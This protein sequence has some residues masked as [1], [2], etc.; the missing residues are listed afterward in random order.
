MI[1]QIVGL[2][3]IVVL[4]LFVLSGVRYIPNNRVGIVEKR[5]SGKGSLKTGFIALNNEAGYQ[6]K[7][8]LS[9][10]LPRFV[11]WWRDWK[12]SRAD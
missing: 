2:A 12:T 9:E 10:G 6:P 5:F 7:V 4:A 11:E 3:V 1:L 8:L